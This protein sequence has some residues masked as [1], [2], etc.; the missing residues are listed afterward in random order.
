VKA[1]S[2]LFAPRT[3]F[4]SAAFLSKK[5]LVQKD[6]FSESSVRRSSRAVFEAP[7]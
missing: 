1:A 4:A 3:T 2:N 5:E 7:E 6:T